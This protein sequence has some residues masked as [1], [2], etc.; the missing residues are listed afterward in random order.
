MLADILPGFDE[1]SKCCGINGGRYI[2][3]PRF[4]DDILCCGIN[5]DRYIYT[6]LIQR[7][8]ILLLREIF[9]SLP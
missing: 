6:D 7:G 4:D 8:T 5:A 9:E 2:I 3:L 1:E